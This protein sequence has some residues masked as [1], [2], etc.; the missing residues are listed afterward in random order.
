M[1]RKIAQFKENE[2][3]FTLI[4]LLVVILII[5]ILA[6]IAIP[7]FLNQQKAAIISS[8]QSDVR[9]TII[10]V[11]LYIAENPNDTT[12]FY[13]ITGTPGSE[14]KIK[15]VRSDPSTT[16]VARGNPSNYFVLGRNTK[17]NTVVSIGADAT[18]GGYKYTTDGFGVLYSS[19][20]GKTQIQNK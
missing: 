4:E 16:M 18:T 9:N 1:F 11:N 17:V 7:V 12:D 8:V 6:A 3:G 15:L 2:S 20:T 5:G 13:A 14:D 19:G 10:N